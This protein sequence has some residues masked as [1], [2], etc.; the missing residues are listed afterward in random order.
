MEKLPVKREIVPPDSQKLQEPLP[1][2]KPPAAPTQAEQLK[3]TPEE[4]LQFPVAMPPLTARSSDDLPKTA[5]DSPLGFTSKRPV[6]PLSQETPL[7][8]S[9]VDGGAPTSKRRLVG[10]DAE[11]AQD[12]NRFGIFSGEK[13]ELPQIK[14]SIQEASTSRDEPE[15]PVTEETTRARALEVNT[16]IEGPIRGIALVYKPAP[17]QLGNIENEVALRLKFWVLPDGTIGEVIPLKRGDAQLERIAIA[18]LKK[19]QFEPL[20]PNVPQ[21]QIWG[22]IPIVFT[23]Q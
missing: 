15:T 1:T 22:T 14:D 19:W 11:S 23:A 17:P 10:L 9:A 20:A 4:R 18:Y 6:R 5:P 8:D 3:P 21:Q 12:K 2:E 13:F 7:P 16:Q